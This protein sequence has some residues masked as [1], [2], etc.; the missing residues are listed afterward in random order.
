MFILSQKVGTVISA[1]RPS[2]SLL[3]VAHSVC[4]SLSEGEQE[5]A[6]LAEAGLA[7]LVDHSL[8]EDQDQVGVIFLLLN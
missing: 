3:R 6:W 2:P 5:E 7:L 8:G 1:D 4:L